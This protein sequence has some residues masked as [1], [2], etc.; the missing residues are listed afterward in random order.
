MRVILVKI[1]NIYLYFSSLYGQ[2]IIR[3]FMWGKHEGDEK[4]LY[5]NIYFFMKKP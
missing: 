2:V 4:I 1:T 5:I 3:R